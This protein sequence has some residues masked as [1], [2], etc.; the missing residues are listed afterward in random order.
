MSRGP[1]DDLGDRLHAHGV[2]VRLSTARTRPVSFRPEPAELRV[3]PLLF[4]ISDA[5]PLLERYARSGGRDG[6]RDLRKLGGAVMAAIGGLDEP[7]A[8]CFLPVLSDAGRER[9]ISLDDQLAAAGIR[10]ELND[11]LRLLLALRHDKAGGLYLGIHYALLEE[12][13]SEE[14]LLRYALRHGRGGFRRLDAAMGRV[15]DRICARREVMPQS[16][17]AGTTIERSAGGPPAI[18]TDFDL[19]AMAATVHATWFAD[20]PRLPVRW[21]KSPGDL[22]QLRSIHFGTFRSRPEPQ[23]RIHPRLGRPWVASCFVEHVLHHE[24]C[25]W[26]QHRHPIRGER[27]HSPRFK[28]WERAYP[29]YAEALAWQRANLNRILAPDLV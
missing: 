14:E 1:I 27:I 9:L 22:R 2:R 28:A 21:S 17:P 18:G 23:I 11:N 20:L 4:A 15:F 7:P 8:R 24:Y 10:L 12:P 29:R 6:G 16:P 25:H 26:R 13:R 19:A 3:H 5:V